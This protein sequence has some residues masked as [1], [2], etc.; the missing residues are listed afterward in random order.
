MREDATTTETVLEELSRASTDGTSESNSLDASGATDQV[1]REFDELLSE[2][3][4]ALPTDEVRFDDAI[5]KE[6][7]EEILLMLIAFREESHGEQLISD[8]AR[9]SKPN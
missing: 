3:D 9:F 6:N 1:E 5:V 4:G 2:V 8:V 7:V